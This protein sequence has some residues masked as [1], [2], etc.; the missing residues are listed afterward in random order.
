MNRRDVITGAV[1]AAAIAVAPRKTEGDMI[2]MV[3]EGVTYNIPTGQPKTMTT[4]A[5]L[6]DDPDVSQIKI[7]I[8]LKEGYKKPLDSYVIERA[9]LAHVGQNLMPW[10]QHCRDNGLKTI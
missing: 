3:H 4:K 7:T 2:R 1:A 5:T 8:T 9:L 6:R 10:L